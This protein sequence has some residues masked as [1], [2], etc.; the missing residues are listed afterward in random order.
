MATSRFDAFVWRALGAVAAA[1]VAAV[2]STPELPPA[3]ASCPATSAAELRTSKT[4]GVESVRQRV[5]AVVLACA[6]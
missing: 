2:T 3:M 6:V 1:A 5:W 4:A